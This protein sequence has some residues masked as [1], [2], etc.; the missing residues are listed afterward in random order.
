MEGIDCALP[1]GVCAKSVYFSAASSLAVLY[2]NSFNSAQ[3]SLQ[4]LD[5]AKTHS[6]VAEIVAIFCSSTKF[7][8]QADLSA[9]LLRQTR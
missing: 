7:H 6:F 1:G 8:A 3:A 2:F 5:L 9:L 4:N